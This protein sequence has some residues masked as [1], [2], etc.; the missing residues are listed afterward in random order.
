MWCRACCAKSTSTFSSCQ[1]CQ[2]TL[3]RQHDPGQCLATDLS[4]WG[5]SPLILPLRKQMQQP[6]Q[7][8]FN[9]L[10]T[11]KLRMTPCSLPPHPRVEKH[12]PTPQGTRPPPNSREVS[13]ALKTQVWAVFE[14]FEEWTQVSFSS[15]HRDALLFSRVWLSVLSDPE[16]GSAK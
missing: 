14:L 3:P 9:F 13:L 7:R 12:K 11:T 1:V 16:P 15:D 6:V 2:S 8:E 4:P 5:I 10:P